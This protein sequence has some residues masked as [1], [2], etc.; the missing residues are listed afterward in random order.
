M[1]ASTKFL[2]MW[3]R[4][5]LATLAQPVDILWKGKV[6]WVQQ[7]HLAMKRLSLV[8]ADTLTQPRRLS[9]KV[10]FFLSYKLF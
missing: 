9:A 6:M 2:M 8:F 4:H 5:Y 1:Y 10:I 7:E 3:T